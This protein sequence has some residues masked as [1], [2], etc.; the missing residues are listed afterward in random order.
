MKTFA[1]YWAKHLILLLFHFL[2]K[3]ESYLY[4][5]TWTGIAHRLG[6]R[7]KNH[8]SWLVSMA[9]KLLICPRV[10]SPMDKLDVESLRILL[11]IMACKKKKKVPEA[12][13]L[14]IC[15]MFI[16]F[17]WKKILISWKK[18]EYKPFHTIFS[19]QPLFFISAVTYSLQ[20]NAN[21]IFLEIYSKHI[22]NFKHQL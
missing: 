7:N 17:H 13:N 4:W 2:C 14:I 3:W 16:Y 11:Y 9:T 21:L 15:T 1:L 22:I 20:L 10:I 18:K 6:H 12:L 19:S 5:P 8:M